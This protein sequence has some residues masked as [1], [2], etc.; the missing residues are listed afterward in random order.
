MKYINEKE[1]TEAGEDCNGEA[2]GKEM[3]RLPSGLIYPKQDFLTWG[4]MDSSDP[5]PKNNNN[6][7]KT[8]IL[9]NLF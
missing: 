4:S 3:F 9:F 6:N 7:K 1:K 8:T 2:Y 5:P